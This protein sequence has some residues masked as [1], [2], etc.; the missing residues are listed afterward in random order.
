HHQVGVRQP[1]VDLPDQLDVQD[2]LARF[3]VEL[4][5][6]VRGAEGHPQRIDSGPLDELHRLVGV[7]EM[8]ARVAPRACPSSMPP[9][10]P[11]SAST[12]TPRGWA[13]STTWRVTR[14]LYS[15]SAGVLPSSRS[16]PCIITDVKPSS[17][18]LW[19]RAG[20][21]A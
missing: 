4:V 11:S 3:V 7:G 14:T 21:L 10:V 15:K 8:G 6:A 18:A 9:M 16:E 17:I 2:V 12:D 20:E 5:G 19:H 1:L 13:I